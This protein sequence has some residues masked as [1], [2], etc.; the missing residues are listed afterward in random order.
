MSLK[1]SVHVTASWCE[2][3]SDVEG[4]DDSD[5]RLGQGRAVT[6]PGCDALASMYCENCSQ[7]LCYRCGSRHTRQRFAVHHKVVELGQVSRQLD[8]AVRSSPYTCLK[9]SPRSLEVYCRDC[10]EVGCLSCLSLDVHQGHAWCEVDTASQETRESLSHHLEQVTTKLEECRQA[11]NR[12]WRSAEALE[13]SLNV[14]HAQL[15]SEVEKLD[16]DLHRCVE[17]LQCKLEAARDQKAQMENRCVELEEQTNRLSDFVAKCHQIVN[18]SSAVD[19]LRSGRELTAEATKLVDFE[20]E[21]DPCSSLRVVFTP[22]NFRQYLPR[23]DVNLV[24]AVSVEEADIHSSDQDDNKPLHDT[25]LQ[26]QQKG[27]FNVVLL[28][29]ATARNFLRYSKLTFNR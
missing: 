2:I 6:A 7:S 5:Q 15:R 29:V 13:Q 1:R 10:N 9:H 19:I 4:Q 28:S 12:Q 21:N 23:T 11:V 26:T 16:Q 27:E 18:S 17:E 14:A 24:G 20:I 8:D 25:V 3:C 22:T